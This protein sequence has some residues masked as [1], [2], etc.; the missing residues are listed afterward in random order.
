MLG[1]WTEA[2]N[3]EQHYTE[4][5]VPVGFKDT[6]SLYNQHVQRDKGMGAMWPCTGGGL[7]TLER[8]KMGMEG[9]VNKVN[10]E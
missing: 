6:A 7:H 2:S 9:T 8:H 5:M 3:E 1:N 10:K 4:R